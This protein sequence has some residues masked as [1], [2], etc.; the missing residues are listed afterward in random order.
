[1]GR[2]LFSIVITAALSLPAA[3][4]AARPE[5]QKIADTIKQKLVEAKRKGK[6][7]G[8]KLDMAVE[9][10]AVTLKGHVSSA[11]QRFLVLDIARRIKGVTQVGNGI[12]IR[13]AKPNL[14][15]AKSAT[16]IAAKPQAAK[17]QAVRPPT[18]KPAPGRSAR[19]LPENDKSVLKVATTPASKNAVQSEK[20]DV[21]NDTGVPKMLSVLKQKA[22]RTPRPPSR[23]E[24]LTR[25]ATP[26]PTGAPTPKVTLTPTAAP[27]S[28]SPATQAAD[29]KA[30]DQH[31]ARTISG[32][33]REKK[34]SGDLRG[35]GINMRVLDKVVTLS[36]HVASQQQKNLVLEISRRVSGVKQVVDGLSIQSPSAQLASRNSKPKPITSVRSLKDAL[37][38]NRSRA[39]TPIES[40]QPLES[41]QPSLLPNDFQQAALAQQEQ[42]LGSGVRQAAQLLPR[43][44]QTAQATQ[45]VEPPPQQSIQLSPQEV[46]ALLAQRGHQAPA[47]YVPGRQPQMPM[48]GH[49][50]ANYFLANQTPLPYAPA[51]GAS[52]G[53]Q[54]GGLPQGGAGGGMVMPMGGT[55]MM[56]THHDQPQMPGYSW[57]SYA[58]HPNYG[59]VTYPKQYSPSAWPYIGPFYPYPQVPLGWRTVTLKWKDG[60]WF[61][62]F[63]DRSQ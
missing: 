9:Q 33:L 25:T 46:M 21:Q 28:R 13:Q 6:L 63:K 30:M 31:I 56:R 8:F 51:R 52:Y 44:G 42:A 37:Q 54:Q 32:Q 59:A 18:V 34:N 57:P 50:G 60:W 1:M 14:V 35:F 36:G 27:V 53:M 16:P 58:P 49:G 48:N 40:Q 4:S 2:F 43:S 26:I 10:G 55:S 5:D 19:R 39:M 62:D 11:E 15:V 38:P 12:T 29:S 61:L 24:T 41:Q 45:A 23:T 17:P 22:A 7:K 47:Q 3:A 20:V